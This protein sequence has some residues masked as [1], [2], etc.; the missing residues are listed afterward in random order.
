MRRTGVSESLYDPS[1]MFLRHQCRLPECSD[2]LADAEIAGCISF[3]VGDLRRTEW[4]QWTPC[5]GSFNYWKVFAKLNVIV[6]GR[7]LRYSVRLR[8]KHGYYSEVKKMG[9]EPLAPAFKPGTD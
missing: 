2:L 5:P 1:Y 7:N 8:S 3:D 4:V 9:Q 6:D